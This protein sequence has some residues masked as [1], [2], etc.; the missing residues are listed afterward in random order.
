MKHNDIIDS[1]S[2]LPLGTYYELQALDIQD[3]DDRTVATVALLTGK[4]EHDVLHAPLTDFARWTAAAA[5]LQTDPPE[6]DAPARRYVAGPFTLIPVLDLEKITAAQFID[7]QAFSPDADSK[8]VEILSCFLIPEGCAYNEGYDIRAVQQAI[9][10]DFT[11]K[12]AIDVSTFF[13]AKFARLLV[14]SRYSLA[15]IRRRTK[16]PGVRAALSARMAELMKTEKLLTL[17]LRNGAGSPA[18]T[19]RA[20]RSAARGRRSGR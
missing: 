16:D 18:W 4:T 13:F 19:A 7:F 6:P 12:D 14:T 1:Y 5:F 8:L 3:A 17:S 10:E 15:R 20:K 2:R 11:V 9:R